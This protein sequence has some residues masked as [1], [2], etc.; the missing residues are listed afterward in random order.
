MRCLWAAARAHPSSTH[1]GTH[2][3]H[4]EDAD[5]G[6]HRH[7]IQFFFFEYELHHFF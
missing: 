5:G 2:A 7:H 4:M 6:D 1:T 3:E